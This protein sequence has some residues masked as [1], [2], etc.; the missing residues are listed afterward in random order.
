[1][2]FI[3]KTLIVLSFCLTTLTGCSQKKI[4][5]VP[6]TYM[7]P[8]CGG[9]RPSKEIEANALLPKVYAHKVVIIVSSKGKVDSVKT[10]ELGILSKK[11]NIG[12]YKVFETW[13]YYKK[14]PQEF[15]VSDFDKICLKEEWKKEI[16]EIIITKTE[17]KITNTNIRRLSHL[18]RSFF[19]YLSSTPPDHETCFFYSSPVFFSCCVFTNHHTKGS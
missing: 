9:A 10:N 7:Q 6:I 1:M 17:T 13:R 2:N 16:A 4:I 3:G 12:T 15:L 11:L 5:T 8:Y 14:A 18:F 19:V